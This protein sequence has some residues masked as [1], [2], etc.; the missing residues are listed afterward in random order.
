MVR[1]AYQIRYRYYEA[2]HQAGATWKEVEDAKL[3]PDPTL[4]FLGD[5]WWRVPAAV[6]LAAAV[7]WKGLEWIGIGD[8]LMRAL[9]VPP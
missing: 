2:R 1:K 5:K 7:A 4:D 9:H 6:L 3:A 8:D